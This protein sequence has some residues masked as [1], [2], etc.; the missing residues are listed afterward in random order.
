MFEHVCRS[1]L[2]CCALTRVVKVMVRRN[3]L[4][5]I[6]HRTYHHSDFVLY[7]D[8]SPSSLWLKLILR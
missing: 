5:L 4:D 7:H 3:L 8:P 2:N 1:R 6:E